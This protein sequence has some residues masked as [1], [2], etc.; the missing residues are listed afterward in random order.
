[1][2]AKISGLSYPWN[3][4]TRGAAYIIFLTVMHFSVSHFQSWRWPIRK[5]DDFLKLIAM[6]MQLSS[7]S[8]SRNN[9]SNIPHW[10]QHGLASVLVGVKCC[11]CSQC[12]FSTDYTYS[13]F[14]MAFWFFSIHFKNADDYPR[15]VFVHSFY[16][17]QLRPLK[18]REIGP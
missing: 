6:S 4:L 13:V 3:Q 7:H 16:S 9:F 14:A 5:Q 8:Q 12:K 10:H 18:F 1:M 11:W 17:R 15:R 2:S